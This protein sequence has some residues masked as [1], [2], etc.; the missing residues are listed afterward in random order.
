MALTKKYYKWASGGQLPDTRWTSEDILRGI[1]RKFLATCREAGIIEPNIRSEIDK[2]SSD[3][4]KNGKTRAK[5]SFAK[6]D[7]SDVHVEALIQVLRQ[8][9]LLMF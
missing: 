9:R 2:R 5:L 4:S 1:E 6:R 7:L 3:A 8:T